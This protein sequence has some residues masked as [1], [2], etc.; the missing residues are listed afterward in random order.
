M[1]EQQPW[2]SDGLEIVV[3]AA[4]AAQA[5]GRSDLAERL[6][7]HR[8]RLAEPVVRVLVAGDYKQ[9]KSTLVNALLGTPACP[10]DDDI[11][12][13]VPLILRYGD[14]PAA[15]AVALGEGGFADTEPLPVE[16]VADVV[17]ES[18]LSVAA[19]RAVELALPSQLLRDGLWLI[20]TPGVGGLES[21]Q[22]AATM[23][24]LP[25]VDAVV[26]VSDAGQEYTRPELDFLVSAARAGA[27]VV[28]ALTKTDFYPEWERIA[29]LDTGHLRAAG[30]RAYFLAV[31]SPLAHAGD[32]H[33][34]LRQDSMIPA[35]ADLLRDEVGGAA[36]ARWVQAAVADVQA[37][38]AQ[39]AAP[40]EAEQRSLT[41]PQHVAALTQE[42]ARAEQRAAR[43]SQELSRWRQT[44][45]DGAEQLAADAEHDLRRRLR[46]LTRE[47][48]QAIA[49]SDPGKV[50]EQLEAR[51]SRQVGMELAASQLLLTAG[52]RE[53][54]QK[55]AEH[56]RLDEADVALPA[57]VGGTLLPAAPSLA[58]ERPDLGQR[59][60]TE[61]GLALFTGAVG[62][63]EALGVLSGAIG[64]AVAG[65]LTIGLGLLFGKRA[66]RSERLSQLATRREEAQIAA[67]R[68]IDDIEFAAL[69][70]IQ[71]TVRQMQQ[72]LRDEFTSRAEQ[73]QRSLA[74]SR[75]AA[76]RAIDE[77]SERS[78]AR[79]DY[80]T[81]ELA[82]LADLCRR[83]GDLEQVAA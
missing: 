38:L 8:Q 64:L 49:T 4:R 51:V 52:A 45:A 74:E 16:Q 14:R 65:P 15:Q 32:G 56:F 76:A 54:A 17:R 41:A 43:L 73:L 46:D 2:A 61:G 23:S 59:T 66:L 78:R 60:V 63:I 20:D 5:R 35:L 34:R 7:P 33:A 24:M 12:T 18:R 70:H 19:P 80:L 6:E 11:A 81:T 48:E 53:L 57:A 71:D 27:V 68:Y 44:L 75:F 36:A 83:A 72:T 69:K 30:V 1:A 10:V 9:G 42:L 79:L 67:E 37:V 47:T 50:W 22:A 62:G 21:P 28:C 55:V 82:D 13:A 39:L 26:F 58:I 31:A 25:W 3:A 77:D 40:L 29:E